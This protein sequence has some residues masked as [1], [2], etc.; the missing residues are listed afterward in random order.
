LA[1]TQAAHGDLP[2]AREI[3]ATL[4]GEQPDDLPPHLALIRLATQQ[5]DLDEALALTEQ[6]LAAIPDNPDLLWTK[7]GLVERKGDIDGAIA[8]YDQLYARDSSSVIVANNLASL[9][10]TWKSDDPAAVARASAVAR[11]LKDTDVPAFMDTYGWIQHL[12]G[13]SQ[14][15]LPYLEGAAAGLADDPI[16]Q[17][18]LGIVQAAL[19][20]DDTAKAQLEKG[21]GMLP[22]GQEGQS[23]AT[24]REALARLN[25]P[26]PTTA[27]ETPAPSGG[28][29]PAPAPDPTVN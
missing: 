26:A 24:A 20:R 19:G 4:I 22:E 7:A 2:A 17:L 23:I 11:R 16:V 10:A 29:T 27:G 6:G 3:F 8:I 5:G 18:H 9:L 21:L 12:N 15:A 28:P 1:M 25:A 14:A 13:D